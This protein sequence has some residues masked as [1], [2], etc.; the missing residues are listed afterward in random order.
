MAQIDRAVAICDLSGLAA[1]RAGA[2]SGGEKRRLNL[3]IALLNN[4]EILYL[5][6]PTVG[7]DARSRRTILDA[8][9]EL[10]RAGA[11]IIY[12]SHYM[13]EV[14][15]I[16]DSIAIITM[17]RIM[18]NASMTQLVAASKTPRARLFV[19]GALSEVQVRRLETM[20]IEA[21]TPREL[22]APARDAA[23]LSELIPALEELDVRIER[24]AFGAGKLEDVY[25][26]AL[27]RA[28]AA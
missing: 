7:I 16:C 21:L 23:A 17:G 20:G 8:I 26:D 15:A 6:E 9:S 18:L 3:A 22:S 4:P 14:E 10:N 2:L 11:T 5:D 1:R 27:R 13:E 12:T 28:E 24:I 19:S 25:L